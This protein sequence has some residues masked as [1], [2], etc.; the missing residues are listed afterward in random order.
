M[1]GST[2]VSVD[3]D[4]TNRVCTVKPHKTPYSTGVR[5]GHSG[6]ALPEAVRTTLP[7]LSLHFVLCISSNWLGPS[8]VP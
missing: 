4:L 3:N 7:L 8:H 6:A 2:E 5:D 1:R